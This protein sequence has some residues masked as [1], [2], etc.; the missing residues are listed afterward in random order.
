MTVVEFS[1]EGDWGQKGLIFSQHHI[2]DQFRYHLVMEVVAGMVGSGGFFGDENECV[3]GFVRRLGG[4]NGGAPPAAGYGG[5]RASE[6]EIRVLEVIR[7]RRNGIDTRIMSPYAV[8]DL[9]LG[10]DERELFIVL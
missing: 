2:L 5:S 6:K 3:A 9:D 10:V 1:C 8:V 4:R 7:K